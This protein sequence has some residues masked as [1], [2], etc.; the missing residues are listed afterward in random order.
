[1]RGCGQAAVAHGM[2]RLPRSD[3]GETALIKLLLT[4][5]DASG[6]CLLP[7]GVLLLEFVEVYGKEVVVVVGNVGESDIIKKPW[8]I[9]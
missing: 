7:W 1:M 2:T 5:G 8:I 4:R 3:F 9:T 6:R